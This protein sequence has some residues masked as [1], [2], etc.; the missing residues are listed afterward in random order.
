[1]I[2]G[3]AKLIILKQEI[4]MCADWYMNINI[5]IRGLREWIMNDRF[6]LEGNSSHSEG[7]ALS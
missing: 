7:R 5:Y 3:R 1:M 4:V 2:S 6:S